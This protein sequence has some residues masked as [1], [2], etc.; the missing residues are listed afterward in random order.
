MT[1][2]RV[3]GRLLRSGRSS[4]VCSLI[5]FSIVALAVCAGTEIRI[6]C[7][8]LPR[9]VAAWAPPLSLFLLS[10]VAVALASLLLRSSWGRSRIF[11]PANQ[12][13]QDLVDQRAALLGVDRVSVFVV[14]GTWHSLD[15]YVRPK[16]VFEPACLFL[17]GGLAV[18][19]RRNSTRARFILEHELAHVA[20]YDAHTLW[21]VRSAIT[22]CL[23]VILLKTFMVCWGPDAYWEAVAETLPRPVVLANLLHVYPGAGETF[24]PYAVSFV[25]SPTPTRRDIVALF[26]TIGLVG[27]CVLALGYCALVRS[28]EYGADRV[29]VTVLAENHGTDPA[30][31]NSVVRSILV[32]GASSLGA[33]HGFLGTGAWHPTHRSRLA[34]LT[35][36][37]T[38]YGSTR[39]WILRSSVPA[40][41]ILASRLIIGNNGVATE[42]VTVALDVISF[43]I[44]VLW[45]SAL[46]FLWESDAV[47][48]S[49]WWHISRLA[50]VATV[51]G[52]ASLVAVVAF[53]VFRSWTIASRAGSSD[54]VVRDSL[55]GGIVFFESA[56][57]AVLVGSSVVCVSVYY[58]AVV[59]V[60]RGFL[61]RLLQVAVGREAPSS[62]ELIVSSAVICLFL[63]MLV[64]WVI[65]PLVVDH[66]IRPYG[67]DML[68]RIEDARI[69]DGIAVRDARSARATCTGLPMGREVV[70]GAVLVSDAR[71]GE[72]TA[73]ESTGARGFGA[74]FGFVSLASHVP[75]VV[76][77][78]MED[79][80]AILEEAL[81]AIMSR[82]RSGYVP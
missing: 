67:R 75:V 56:A 45:A 26:V 35:R 53:I 29:A 31:V 59:M 25:A 74:P 6:A 43:P 44:C 9:S 13:L 27:L 72:A 11:D 12:L 80:G 48:G 71:V 14:R 8:L 66:V 51:F 38:T 77:P 21:L 28:R 49:V 34:E 52:V 68:E 23:T 82:V 70:C 16:G 17:A 2:Q 73:A 36:P 54:V 7:A 37:V 15:A 40:V 69:E 30:S 19:L 57:L 10:M 61:R 5:S 78:P 76:A 65:N 4:N 62:F 50:R 32:D 41:A 79:A 39:S 60:K 18:E 42:Q 47:D 3:V 22:L 1:S 58:L 55:G 33:P 64:T 63:L 20:T 24:E 81:R 46:W